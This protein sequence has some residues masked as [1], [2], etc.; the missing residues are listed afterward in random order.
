M[1]V[2]G[3]VIFPQVSVAPPIAFAGTDIARPI[4]QSVA[5]TIAEKNFGTISFAM[6]HF[7]YIRMMY[8]PF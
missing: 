5:D 4:P 7:I 8:C 6:P 3:W 1:W 2:L